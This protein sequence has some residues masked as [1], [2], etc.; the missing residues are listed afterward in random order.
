M[1]RAQS[2]RCALDEPP[3]D[4]AGARSAARS[5][6]RRRGGRRPGGLSGLA[7][8][9]QRVRRAGET[10]TRTLVPLAAERDR[11]EALAAVGFRVGRHG[12]EPCQQRSRPV[13]RAH[14]QQPA[15]LVQSHVPCD[16]A[17]DREDLCVAAQQTDGVRG[18][19]C[20]AHHCHSDERHMQKQ[21][22]MINAVSSLYI[23]LIYYKFL[24]GNIRSS[25]VLNSHLHTLIVF[26][27]ASDLHFIMYLL[28]Y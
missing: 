13:E 4:A 9:V 26:I 7:A 18:D 12:C 1:P 6:G 27:C 16:S 11:E 28:F 19:F 21:C 10:V 3:A 22:V 23:I 17:Q 24:H 25:T 20:V 15:R 5:S 2:R 8:G 14:H